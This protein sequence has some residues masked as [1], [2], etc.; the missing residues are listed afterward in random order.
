MSFFRAIPVLV[1]CIKT[2]S[3][4]LTENLLDLSGKHLACMIG[5]KCTWLVL[6]FRSAAAFSLEVPH[7]L[8][9]LIKTPSL[10]AKR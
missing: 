6:H 3:F 1:V 8:K 5:A 4:E 10:A 7:R 9:Y 2:V